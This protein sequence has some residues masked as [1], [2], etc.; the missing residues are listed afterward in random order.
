M[1]GAHELP[2]SDGI[3]G[4][5]EIQGG[6]N[7]LVFPDDVAGA[8][9]HDIGHLGGFQLFAGDIAESRHTHDAG[10]FE[11]LVP[12]FVVLSAG[13]GMF[14]AGVDDDEPTPLGKGMVSTDSARQSR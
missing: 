8:A 3:S 10:G 9:F 13:E 1:R 12:T 6:E 14:H 11:A 4:A 5:E 2:E 7:A